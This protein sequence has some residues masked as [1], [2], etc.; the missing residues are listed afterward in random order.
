[1]QSRAAQVRDLWVGLGESVLIFDY[2]GYGKSD[3]TPSEAGCYAAA[4]AAYQWLTHEGGVPAGRVLLYGESLGGAVAVDLASRQPHAALVLVR[5]FTSLPDV[6]DYQMP[7]FPGFLLMHNR[8][9]SLAK[10]GQCRRPVFIAQ[11]DADAL[12]PV[13][14]GEAL[15]RACAAPVELHVLRG[16]GHNDPLPT[17]FYPDLRTFLA[18]THRLRSEP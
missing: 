16:L 5:T 10:L 4:D 13:R 6:A 18:R 17:D 8:F 7:L 9:D 11:A 15:R 1:M 2:P 3:G 14:H 12:I